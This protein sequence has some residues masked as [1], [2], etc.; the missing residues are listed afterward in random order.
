MITAEA[1]LP[2]S[3]TELEAM[4]AKQLK[5]LLRS[6][7]L[8]TKGTKVSLPHDCRATKSDGCRN[9]RGA[10]ICVH[11][12]ESFPLFSVLIDCRTLWSDGCWA[13]KGTRYPATRSSDH[14]PKTKIFIL[15]LIK[16]SICY[17]WDH[18]CCCCR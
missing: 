5:A 13:H 10:L 18:F 14:W 1:E 3:S 8:D 9:G 7:G 2:H 12:I 17:R 16:F 11:F 15:K 6:M 4:N